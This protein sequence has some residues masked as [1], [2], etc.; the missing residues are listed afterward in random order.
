MSFLRV[1]ACAA[2][3]SVLGGVAVAQSGTNVRE[4]VTLGARGTVSIDTYKGSIT[5]TTWDRDEVEVEARIEADENADLVE[6]TDVEI[7][8]RGDRVLIKSNYDR[9]KKKNSVLGVQ[10]GNMSLPFVH[11]TIKM[12]RTARLSID[13]YKSDIR[14]ENLRADLA[15]DT[16]KSAIDVRGVVGDVMIDTY[17]NT[18][19]LREIVGNV[20]VDAYRPTVRVG[21]LKGA[22]QVDT[23]RG[24]IEVAFDALE[25]DSRFETSRGDV[26][27]A[28]PRG[29]GF[30]LD[31]DLDR[32][33]S[34]TSDFDVDDLRVRRDRDTEYR[35]P[36]NG[37]GPLLA[38][39]TSRGSVALRAR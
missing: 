1:A 32:R 39:E 21:G 6:L 31:A 38:F 20:T 35:G 12:P 16:Y 9:A 25:G 7:E 4:T 17:K 28:L 36:V 33:G 37:G 13:D 29:A 3:L 34:L 30:R 8:G 14:V 18:V 19:D 2:L 15:I 27:I 11:Y 10:W 24:D 23:Y 26:A 22:I 5:V